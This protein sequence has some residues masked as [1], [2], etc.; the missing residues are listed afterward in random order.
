[1]QQVFLCPGG[2][3][4][5][6]EFGLFPQDLD[7]IELGTVGRQ[8]DKDEPMVVQPFVNFFFADIVMHRRIVQDD[9]DGL[10]VDVLHC[11]SIDEIDDL[12]PLDGAF[13]QDMCERVGGIVECAKNVHSLARTTGVGAM[14]HTPWRPCPLHVRHGRHPRFV[15]KI[16]MGKPAS[17]GNF[18]LIK[19][20]FFLYEILFGTLFFS[21]SRQRLKLNPRPFKRSLSRSRL[22]SGACG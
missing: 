19:H 10:A 15:E 12:G 9:D 17:G 4:P 22:K 20:G 1:M 2:K 5:P 11:Q 16:Q 7:R 21:D 13:M 8:I 14:W 6:M 3:F 18:Q